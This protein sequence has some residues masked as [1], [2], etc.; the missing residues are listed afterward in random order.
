MK[1]LK[2][3]KIDD[4]TFKGDEKK[5]SVFVMKSESIPLES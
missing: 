4:D 2:T 3:L 5:K 1:S